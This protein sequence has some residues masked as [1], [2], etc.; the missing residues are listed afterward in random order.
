V[1][2]LFA[3]REALG[4]LGDVPMGGASGL[5]VAKQ[6]LAL[7]LAPGVVLVQT[8]SGLMNPALNGIAQL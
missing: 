7:T 2:K 1:G 3:L 4:L 8:L 5:E 6:A